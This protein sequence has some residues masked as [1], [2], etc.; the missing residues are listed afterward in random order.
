[1]SAPLPVEILITPD[2]IADPGLMHRRTGRAISDINVMLRQIAEHTDANLSA[3]LRLRGAPMLPPG[4][5]CTD[6]HRNYA[7]AIA[8][9][10]AAEA[11][12]RGHSIPTPAEEA[13][14]FWQDYDKAK[15]AR[16][17]KP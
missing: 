15:A 1:M 14:A 2:L 3:I 6:H 4:V 8:Q 9:L 10:D 13:A 7:T 16:S 11:V 12:L 5:E 17:P